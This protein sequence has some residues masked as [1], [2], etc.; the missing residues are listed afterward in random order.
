MPPRRAA[1]GDQIG[2]NR[3]EIPMWL[4]STAGNGNGP[5]ISPQYPPRFR[6]FAVRIRAT[7]Y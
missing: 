5:L 3:G 7:H 4:L 1:L 2:A 6:G